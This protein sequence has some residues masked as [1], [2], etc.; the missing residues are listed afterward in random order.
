MNQINL[1]VKWQETSWDDWLGV[2]DKIYV[3][4][5]ILL[6]CRVFFCCWM[7][8]DGYSLFGFENFYLSLFEIFFLKRFSFS[9]FLLAM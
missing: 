3:D 2:K 4:Q 8:G 5:I 6:V 1:N 7:R 9:S